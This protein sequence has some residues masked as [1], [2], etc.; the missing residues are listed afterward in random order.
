MCK[1]GLGE[2]VQNLRKEPT[3]FHFI[4]K[5]THMHLPLWPKKYSYILHNFCITCVCQHW[6]PHH[7]YL[8]LNKVTKLVVAKYWLW[9]VRYILYKNLKI[10]KLENLPRDIHCVTTIIIVL[11]IY[12]H[13]GQITHGEH[14]D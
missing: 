7:K 2:N 5:V 3:R 12:M 8:F 13:T 4:G 9:Q 1:K 11:S 6:M 10:E 14:K